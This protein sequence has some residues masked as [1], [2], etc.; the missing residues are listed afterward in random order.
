MPNLSRQEIAEILAPIEGRVFFTGAVLGDKDQATVHGA[1]VSAQNTIEM[2]L[3][4]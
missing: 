1:A 3:G 2:M 4:A